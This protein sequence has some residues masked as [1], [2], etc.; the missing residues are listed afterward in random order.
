MTIES[1]EK[2]ILVYIIE[3]MRSG[4]SLGGAGPN[5]VLCKSSSG[6]LCV[7]KQPWVDNSSM[8]PLKAR[9]TIESNWSN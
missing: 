5:G 1:N 8:G 7:I 6:L 9:S 3:Y 2:C 4:P